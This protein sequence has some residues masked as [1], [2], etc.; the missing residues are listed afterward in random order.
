[1]KDLFTPPAQLLFA[2]VVPDFLEL[3]SHQPDRQMRDRPVRKSYEDDKFR[4]G[5]FRN[6][7]TARRV[8]ENYISSCGVI[9]EPEAVCLEFTGKPL[10]MLRAFGPAI[11][12]RNR[13]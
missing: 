9:Y 13:P 4:A 3:L 1:M 7:I 10:G 2:V 5:V 12:D 6:L 8:G 11:F